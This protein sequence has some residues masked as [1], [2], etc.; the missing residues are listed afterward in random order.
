MVSESRQ[1]GVA[2]KYLKEKIIDSDKF[3]TSPVGDY[4]S[5]VGL[6]NESTLFIELCRRTKDDTWDVIRFQFDP[7]TTSKIRKVLGGSEQ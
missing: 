6:T 7:E 2:I 1:L 3:D 4:S 5:I